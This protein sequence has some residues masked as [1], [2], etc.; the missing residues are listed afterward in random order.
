MNKLLHAEKVKEFFH[1]NLR[2]M[3]GG[4]ANH[5]SPKRLIDL[6]LES[7]VQNITV[8]SN[9]T[10]DPDLSTGRLVRSRQAKKFI[11]SHVG[12]NPEA[13]EAYAAGQLELEL[14]PQ[15]NLAERI[16]CGGAGLGGALVKTGL[17]TIIEENKQKVEINGET[18]LLE[19]PLR[20][21]IALV[22]AYKADT[23]G[24]LTYRGTSCNFNPLIAMAA[25][26]VIVEADEIVPAGTLM[27]NEIITP[28]VFVT[29]ILEGGTK[30]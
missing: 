15:G 1:D 25:D 17:G 2:V 30:K 21:E 23:A 24:N 14:C 27:P 8:I 5:G 12:M 28:F 29:Y 6:V 9:D 16:R 20:A 11:A 10:G 19:T 13:C 4:F 7:K 26:I 3:I 18:W 22:K